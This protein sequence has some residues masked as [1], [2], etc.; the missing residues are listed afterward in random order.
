V[1]AALAESE[2]A[3]AADAATLA[4]KRL[5]AV[6]ATI[7]KAKID[8][9]RLLEDKRVDVAGNDEAEVQLNLADSEQPRGPGRRAPEFLRRLTSDAGAHRVR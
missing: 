9:A 2:T 1:R 8:T 3:P 6:R 7:K 4:D 5:E